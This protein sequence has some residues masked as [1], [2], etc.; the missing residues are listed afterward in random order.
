M[1]KETIR[2]S[3]LS[4]TNSDQDEGDGL[5]TGISPVHDVVQSY[6]IGMLCK[7]GR[8]RVGV[9]RTIAR[10]FTIICLVLCSLTSENNNKNK[11]KK[12]TLSVQLV[13]HTFIHCVSKKQD[14]KLLPIT[15]PNV[16]RFSK[17]FH[18]KTHW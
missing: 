13:M 1:L 18:W 9:V 17:F 10:H 14:T 8:H 3:H 11:R 4:R 7:C 6:S 5:F 2:H 12:S 15:S 16:N